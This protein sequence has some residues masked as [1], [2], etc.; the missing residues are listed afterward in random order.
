V[1]EAGGT[2]TDYDGADDYLF[3]GSIIAT[4]SHIH[5]E[6]QQ[7]INKYRPVEV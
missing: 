1:Q 3:G 7:L 2:V 5:K 6:M 4:N